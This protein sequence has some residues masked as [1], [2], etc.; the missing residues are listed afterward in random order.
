MKRLIKRILLWGTG[1]F[2]LLVIVLFVHIWMVTGNK[3]QDLRKRQLARIEI[4]QPVDSLQVNQ[5]RAC[6]SSQEGVRTTLYTAQENALIYELDPTVQTTDRVLAE[7]ASQTGLSLKKFELSKEQS[8]AGCPVMNENSFSYKL[9][10][11]FERII[12]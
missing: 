11:V 6:I 5:L 1:V 2:L 4:L 3:R 10:K 7:A 8:I 12:N 9:G